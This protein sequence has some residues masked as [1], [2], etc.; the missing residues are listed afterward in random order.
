[1]QFLKEE[2]RSRVG[3]GEEEREDVRNETRE[4]GSEIREE[5]E[6]ENKKT[7]RDGERD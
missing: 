2:K 1:M 3:R 6:S 5:E 4:R 7:G